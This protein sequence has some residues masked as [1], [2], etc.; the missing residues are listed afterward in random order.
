[1]LELFLFLLEEVSSLRQRPLHWTEELNFVKPV[2][3]EGWRKS[4][5]GSSECPRSQS[6]YYTDQLGI[7]LLWTEGKDWGV[8][9]IFW[10]IYSCQKSKVQ[11]FTAQVSANKFHI[12]SILT[13][14]VCYNDLR[15]INDLNFCIRTVLLKVFVLHPDS[16]LERAHKPIKMHRAVNNG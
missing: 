6:L 9:V 1:M 5:C 16:S 14:N 2:A 8:S 12:V 11:L 13:W 10:G 3:R 7:E 4:N 15:S